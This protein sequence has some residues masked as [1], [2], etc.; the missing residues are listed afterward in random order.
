M[1]L[2]SMY[3]LVVYMFIYVVMVQA[4]Y[5]D[6]LINNT[7]VGY[8][9]RECAERYAVIKKFL[10][11]YTRPFTILDLGASQGYFSFKIAE[12]FKD[13]SQKATCV[14]IEGN[15]N[16][17]Q[18]DEKIADQLEE[19]CKK[20]SNLDSL[21]LLK[22]N[23]TAQELEILSEC[24]HID[25][26]LAL[27][28]VHHFGPDWKRV[29][30]ALLAMGDHIIIQT[31][32]AH[33]TQAA[34]Q[35]YIKAIEEYLESKQGVIIGRFPRQTN[36]KMLDKMFLF[37]PYKKHLKRIHWAN[38]L[39]VERYQDYCIE[40]NFD[41]KLLHKKHTSII[42]PWHRGINL[43]TYKMLNGV[44]PEHSVIKEQ[45]GMLEHIDHNDLKIWNIIIQG[46]SLVPIDG[47]DAQW[48]NPHYNKADDFK[49]LV[50]WF[51]K[52]VSR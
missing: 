16:T 46:K 49:V 48:N 35:A 30:D 20:N 44:F 8:G 2:C 39:P 23:I 11:N 18:N 33:D 52:L 45:L 19:L 47:D 37:S 28:V 42:R 10:N 34:G 5:Q 3:M 29:V 43:L 50:E 21:I 14:M 27:N 25:V 15:Y 24:E 1:A 6:I 12:D 40:S 51:R 4:H 17:Q 26:V 7:V 36:T 38:G 41:K 13:A 9:S 32:P 31:P 22:K